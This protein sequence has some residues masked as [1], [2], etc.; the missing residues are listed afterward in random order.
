[1]K[2]FVLDSYALLSYCEGEAGAREVAGFFKKALVNKV[3]LYLSVVNWGE[4]YY[5]ALREGGLER[6]EL[7]RSTIARY[8]MKTITAG[9]DQ[10]LQAAIFKGVFRISYADAYA[11]ALAKLRGATL[12]TG[13]NE[14]A[15]LQKEISIHWIAR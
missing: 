6:A 7:Y 10:T 5:I 3:R 13:D 1:M 15:P 8:P 11:A 9:L 14:F 12:I 2:D 4:M